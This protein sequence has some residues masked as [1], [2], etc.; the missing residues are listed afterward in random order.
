MKTRAEAEAL[1]ATDPAVMAGALAGEAYML[2]GSAALQEVTGI[3][4]RISRK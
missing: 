2:Y 4:Y 1:V 3:H